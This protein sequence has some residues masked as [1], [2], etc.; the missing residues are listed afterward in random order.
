[1]PTAWRER[2]GVSFLIPWIFS[3]SKYVKT[4]V[5]I[6]GGSSRPTYHVA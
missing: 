5:L 4:A 3:E 6:H 2:D 1:M